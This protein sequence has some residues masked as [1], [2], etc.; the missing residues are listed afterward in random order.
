[1]MSNKW[2]DRDD[3]AREFLSNKTNEFLKLVVTKTVEVTLT[4]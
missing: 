2:K 3:L 1:M 4:V